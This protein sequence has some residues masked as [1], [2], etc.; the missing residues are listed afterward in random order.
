M[1]SKSSGHSFFS[2]R[3][4]IYYEQ[5]FLPDGKWTE[6]E[7]KIDSTK[8]NEVFCY[9]RPPKYPCGMVLEIKTDGQY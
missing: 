9:I 6:T 1:S 7:R 8:E 2:K 5:R 4:W 3:F